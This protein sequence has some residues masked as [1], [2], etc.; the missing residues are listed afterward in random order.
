M[1]HHAEI[2]RGGLWHPR[3]LSWGD[4]TALGLVLAIIVLIGSGAR[5]MVA[6]FVAAQQ[7]EISLSPEALPAYA[8]RTT[9]RMLGALVASLL[10]TL[11]YATLAAKSRR[12]EMV[13]IPLLDVLQSVP[14]R[15]SVVHYRILRRFSPEECSGWS[16]QRFSR[17]SP[18]KPGTWPSAFSKR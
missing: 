6:P 8:L 18:V 5:Q 3:A 4:L 9:M 15:L 7:P 13:L 17:S 12:A 16:S 10:F 2:L 11:T 1:E 14:A